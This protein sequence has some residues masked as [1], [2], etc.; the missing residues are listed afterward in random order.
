MRFLTKTGIY[1]PEEDFTFSEDNLEGPLLSYP[2]I[3][4]FDS[5]TSE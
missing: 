3:V 4:P 2:H 5:S 1:L